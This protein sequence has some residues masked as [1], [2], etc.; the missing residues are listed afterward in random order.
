MV[1]KLNLGC[2]I[3]VKKGFINVDLYEPEDLKNHIG[4][5]AN[6]IWEDDAVYVK[7]DIRNLPFANDSADYVEMFEVIEHLPIRDLVPTLKEIRRVM[8]P[9]AE[10]LMH[11]P[12][13]DGLM[14]DWMVTTYLPFDPD[15]YISV[16]E[17]IYGNQRAKGE[18]HQSALNPQFMD[19]LVQQAGF[20]H[21]KIY[22]IP[23]N[24]PMED[25]DIG[26]EKFK[27]GTVARNEILVTEVTK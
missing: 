5:C 16:M 10:L 24:H 9:G 3:K 19:W 12:N 18:F 1:T 23:K 15:G 14:K 26:S 8:K 7:A 13:F 11:C 25:L 17:T 27:A 20:G 4:V 6:S 22:V 2:G 21:G